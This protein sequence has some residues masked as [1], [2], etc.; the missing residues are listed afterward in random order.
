MKNPIVLL[1]IF[2][3]ASSL[4]AQQTA[5]FNQQLQLNISREMIDNQRNKAIGFNMTFT[6]QEK[7]KFWPL[8]REYRGAMHKVGDKRVAVI[9]DYAENFESM[10]DSLAR[11]LMDRS[12]EAESERIK[13]KK[14][15]VAK[16]R[17]ILPETKVVRLMQIESRMD[18]L[19][20]LKIA[21]SLPL[22]E[23][24]GSE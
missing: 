2:G 16:F 18:T 21:E 4:S 20:D 15:Y 12:L 9:L 14:K 24:V 22:M 8:Y 1:L 23:G 17:R 3:L 7:E 11:N 5:V 10:T 13:V 19:V 6:Q